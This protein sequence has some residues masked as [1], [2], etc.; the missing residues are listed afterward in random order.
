[1]FYKSK[2]KAAW[3]LTNPHF[4]TIAAKLFRRKK[5][6]ATSL[7][8]IELPDG[9]FIDLAWTERPV[10]INSNSS[11]SKNKPIVV[12]LHGLEGSKDSHYSRGMLAT[13]KK[14]QW[15][16]LLMH[17]RGC[18]GRPN[19]QAQSY[20]SGDTRDITYL[21]QLLKERYPNTPLAIVAISLGAN[22]LTRFLAEVPNNPYKAA[23]AICT[24]L[25]LASCS[26]RVNVGFSK[27]YQKYLV[28]ML[29]NSML[30]KVALNL[31]P[32]V[33]AKRLNKI[34]TILAFDEYV[35]A[36]LNGFDNA[37]DYYDKVSGI[38]TIASIKQPCLFIHSKDDPFLNHQ[39]T[40]P[41][42][43]LPSNIT[44]EITK[45]GGHVGFVSGNNPFKP[46]YWLD[47]RV[48]EYL[49]QYI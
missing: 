44:F 9:D 10:S 14:N 6:I 28:D 45:K 43:K 23:C 36:P 15:I 47:Q 21:T 29:R 37:A 2:F 39:K 8:T 31:L 46:V 38:H 16:G 27:V 25:D 33:E 40:V 4:Q 35:T 22:V 11:K 12:V 13:I 5:H 17:F 18:S 20:H 30:E 1:M 7:E 24:P 3:W 32:N 41:T 48:P 19:R 34:K 49:Q 42:D 26:A